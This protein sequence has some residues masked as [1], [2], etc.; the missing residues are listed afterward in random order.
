MI[1][2]SANRSKLLL[3]EFL[4]ARLVLCRSSHRRLTVD[5]W[6]HCIM[7]F[8]EFID[9]MLDHLNLDL[10]RVPTA[11]LQRVNRDGTELRFR[12]ALF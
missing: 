7:A 12:L 9:M 10:P 5:N 11:Y 4:G 8:L 6:P 2:D 1:Y 3:L